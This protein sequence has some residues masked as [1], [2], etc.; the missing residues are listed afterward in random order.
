MSNLNTLTAGRWFKR[1]LW[2]GILA[3]LALAVPALLAPSQVL[4][5]SSLPPATP[6]VWTQFAAL[7]L[8]LLSISASLCLEVVLLV[9]AARG[10]WE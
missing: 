3:N 1:V 5:L 10:A 7:L 4:A 8:V 6:L 2:I 9:L